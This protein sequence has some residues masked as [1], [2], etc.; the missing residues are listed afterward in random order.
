VGG[1]KPQRFFYSVRYLAFV[2]TSVMVAAQRADTGAGGA[3]NQCTSHRSP[4]EE[5]DTGTAGGTNR[6]AR[7]APLLLPAHARASSSHRQYRGQ[8]GAGDQALPRKSPTTV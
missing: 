5:T 1:P 4:G 3:T 7:Q 2:V 8:H 6:A